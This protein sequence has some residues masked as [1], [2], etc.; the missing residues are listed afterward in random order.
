MDCENFN[1]NYYTTSQSGQTVQF[2]SFDSQFH[3]KPQNQM[4]IFQENLNNVPMFNGNQPPICN[5][6][7]NPNSLFQFQ[8]P[9]PQNNFPNQSNGDFFSKNQISSQNTPILF[10]QPE[11]DENSDEEYIPNEM[12]S[13]MEEDYLKNNFVDERELSDAE[14]E[15][16]LQEYLKVRDTL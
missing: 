16:N 4:N 15:F 5:S 1:P 7:S 6:F 12:D 13:E 10:Q 8:N 9:L 14:G 11:I 3:Q 2:G